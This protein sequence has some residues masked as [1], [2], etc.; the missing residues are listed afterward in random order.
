M[1]LFIIRADTRSY[2]E[3][4]R[5]SLLAAASIGLLIT[6][7]RITVPSLAASILAM[8]Y[9][10][11][12]RALWKTARRHPDVVA[13]NLDYTG[14][15]VTIGALVGAIWTLVFWKGEPIFTLDFKNVPLFIINALAS[16]LA[17]ALG[18]SILFPVD[19]EV[20]NAVPHTVNA[21]VHQIWDASTLLIL[22]GI[23]GCHSTLSIRRSYTNIYQFCC[24]FLA[25]ICIE[26]RA[27]VDVSKA[28]RHRSLYSD[29]TH[30]LMSS[31]STASIEDNDTVGFTEEVRYSGMPASLLR[32]RN[33]TFHRFLL[34]IGIISLWAA[35]TIL[36]SNERPQRRIPV[37][38]DREY[39]PGSLVEIV[40]SMYNEPV[41]EVAKLIRDLRGFPALSD[42]PVTIYIK[43]S[44]ADID[45]I[46][47]RTRANQI[48][49]LPNIGREGETYL[50]H[51][52]NRWDS[53]AK[54]TIFLQAGI[55]NPR[56]FF[57]HIYNYYSRSQTGFLNL[58]WSGTVCN[59]EDCGDRMFWRDKTHIFQQVYTKIN[60][61][62]APCESL[63]LSY[64]GQ[65]IVS[66]ARIRG[67]SK[68]IYQD[69]WQAFTD[70]K[71]WAHQPAYLQGRP[72]SLSA[73]DFGYTMER[74]WN[75]LFQ[76]SD[77]DVAWRCPSLV[78]RWRIGGTIGD[79]Q[80]FDE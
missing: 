40:L 77:I 59:C 32:S 28:Q 15:Y 65:F 71:S 26:N 72:D 79:C 27:H 18:K 80:C 29:S 55:H 62:S 12:A 73:P 46:K 3:L 60:N 24:F 31:S 4:L 69:L 43:D 44:E 63:L 58:G 16:S 11:V 1:S 68:D 20:P 64:K 74:M 76:C 25:I 33:N 9:A 39:S 34:Y 48:T 5:I 30:D 13:T 7:H 37:L 57:A 21:P 2:A 70:D 75:L 35:Y 42:A 78:S 47:Q 56:E 67:I 38:L 53:L 51:I 49:S 36:N 50:N 10:G 52:L 14:R 22:T 54:Q 23:V 19:D 8:L 41:D 6:D 45:D 66:A 61:D 17:L